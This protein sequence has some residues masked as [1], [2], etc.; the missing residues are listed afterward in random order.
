MATKT[1]TEIWYKG[2]INDLLTALD[3]N[4]KG[5]LETI[6]SKLA[7]LYKWTDALQEYVIREDNHINDYKTL[8]AKLIDAK[9]SPTGN[10]A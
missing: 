6:K 8:R 10:K 2:I 4:D 9:Q 3:D 7:S 1:S 5:S